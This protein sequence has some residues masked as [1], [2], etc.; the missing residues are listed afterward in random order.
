MACVSREKIWP[1]PCCGRAGGAASGAIK[2][3]CGEGT[4]WGW[5]CRGG[6]AVWAGGRASRVYTLATRACAARPARGRA[7]S[8][9]RPGARA[10]RAPARRRAPDP[11]HAAPP[12]GGGPR[13]P[14][15]AA[16]AAGGLDPALEVAVPPDQR[17][18]NELAALR[19]A[20]LYSW[21]RA[22]RVEG[23]VEAVAA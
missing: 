3:G 20:S 4:G 15:G 10:P 17:P 14:P 22:G 16:P 7:R 5:G 9:P 8:P 21:V 12:S 11:P 19:T 23:G 2:E 13:L 1:A 18:V 6:Q